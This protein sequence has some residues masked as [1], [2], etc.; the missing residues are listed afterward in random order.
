MRIP[1][2][3]TPTHTAS[4][5]TDVVRFTTQFYL[6]EETLRGGLYQIDLAVASKRR[7]RRKIEN[8]ENAAPV[9][10]KTLLDKS[11]R[12]HCRRALF[13]F[14]YRHTPQPPHV[15]HTR[16]RAHIMQSTRGNHS[17]SCCS[18]CLKLLAE[19]ATG[20]ELGDEDKEMERNSICVRILC[21]SPNHISDVDK[22][23]LNDKMWM[24]DSPDMSMSVFVGCTF[25]INECV[26]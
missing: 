7:R 11:L 8:P 4:R 5:S 3:A 22:W 20:W 19:T 15:V 17:D 9:S 24:N 14:R 26:M 23:R 13:S 1:N 10:R 18:V 21:H 2:P 25:S 16:T 6:S 12:Q